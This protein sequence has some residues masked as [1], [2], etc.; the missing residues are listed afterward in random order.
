MADALR[1]SVTKQAGLVRDL[2]KNGAPQVGRATFRNAALIFGRDS[3]SSGTRLNRESTVDRRHHR[4][5][6]LRRRRLLKPS[7]HSMPCERSW[8]P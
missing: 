8:M 5:W 2:K 6:Y 7:R 1:A 3:A 4:R